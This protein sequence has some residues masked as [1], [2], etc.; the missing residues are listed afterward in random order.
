MSELRDVLKHSK[1]YLSATVASKALS[2]ISLPILTALLTPADYGAYQVFISYLGLL[3]VILT[4]NF[5]GSVARYYYEKTND[6]GEFLSTSLIGSFSILS[7]FVIFTVI[8][9]D[10]IASVLGMPKDLVVLLMVAIAMR[11]LFS[12]FSHINIAQSKSSQ[13][14]KVMVVKSYT[15]FTL[16]LIFVFVLEHNRYKGL[17]YAD[18]IVAILVA[19]YCFAS[20]SKLIKRSF[21]KS[22]IKY[23]LGYS[24]SLLPYL[25]SGVIL[26]QIDRVMINGFYGSREVGLYSVAYNIG[27]MLTL[28]VNAI[29]TAFTPKWFDLKKQGSDDRV[30]QIESNLHLIVLFFASALILFSNELFM[31]LVN[32]AFH[33]SKHIVPIV[34]IAYVCES[35]FKVYGRVIGYTKKMI[36]MSIVGIFGALINVLLNYIYIPIYGYEAGA[37]TTLI[38]FL[39]M[40]L[41]AVWIAKYHLRQRTIPLTVFLRPTGFLFLIVMFEYFI[42]LMDLSYSVLLAGKSL[43]FGGIAYIFWKMVNSKNFIYQT[44]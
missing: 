1:N 34:V 5:N 43:V 22:H 39:S 20:I 7:V 27:S 2:V 25:L 15:A 4:L 8:Y 24:V 42:P 10:L 32:N 36:F 21:K 38:A 44:R 31:L 18:I 37:V 16:G 11:L 14:A 23:I 28:V 29:N 35:V 13:L 40:L 41:L 9:L 6:F 19:A 17:V 3:S 30:T 33:A 12:T 26:G